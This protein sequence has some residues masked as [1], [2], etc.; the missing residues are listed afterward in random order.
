[1]LSLNISPQ[2]NTNLLVRNCHR[3]LLLFQSFQSHLLPVLLLLLLSL[4][5]FCFQ[6]LEG[7]LEPPQNVALQNSGVL[8]LC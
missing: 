5:S 6:A 8:P 1:M 3:L 2:V 7:A 4:P